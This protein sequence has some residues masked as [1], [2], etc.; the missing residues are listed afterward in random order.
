MLPRAANRVTELFE[1]RFISGDGLKL[2]DKQISKL[3][4]DQKTFYE[5]FTGYYLNVE[6]P[7]I[8]E[9]YVDVCEYMIA[10][11]MED[12]LEENQELFE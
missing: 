1:G 9:L 12:W 3:S 10:E 4:A 2:K 7:R 6:N 8:K 11:F 5:Y